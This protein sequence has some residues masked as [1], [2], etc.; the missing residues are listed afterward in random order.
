MQ[1][2]ILSIQDQVTNAEETRELSSIFE[3]VVSCNIYNYPFVEENP[4]MITTQN[5]YPL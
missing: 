3:I 5:V 4:Y 1:K 2:G